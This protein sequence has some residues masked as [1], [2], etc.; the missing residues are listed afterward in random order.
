VESASPERSGTWKNSLVRAART[1]VMNSR[2]MGQLLTN[3]RSS[4]GRVKV[5]DFL[6]FR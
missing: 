5:V 4:R 2:N 3:D 1:D 6:D